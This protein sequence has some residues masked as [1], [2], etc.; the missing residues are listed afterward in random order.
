[1]RALVVGILAACAS[2]S[3]TSTEHVS[4]GGEVA[5]VGDVAIPADLVARVAA[6]RHVTAR[7]AAALLIDDALAANAAHARGLDR[8]PSATWAIQALKAR[9]VASKLREDALAAGPPTDVEVAERSA[10]HWREV[11]VPEAVRVIHA[12]ALRPTKATAEQIARARKVASELARAV[13]SASSAEEFEQKA[14]AVAHDGIDV[15]VERLPAFDVRGRVIEQDGGM[16]ATFAAS[17]YALREPGVTSAIVETS[18]GWHVI[19][20]IERIPAK[21]I[22]LERRRTLFTDEVNATRARH[23]LEA[24]VAARRASSTVEIAP[25]A[26]VLMNDVSISNR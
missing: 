6:V 22:T 21:Q 13:T 14:S 23:A 15:K 10:A 19:R 17:A 26:T 3:A 7:E 12:V 2:P 18:F 5:R 20:L 24:I 25:G 11:D 4:L 1:M 9:V 16:D 8:T